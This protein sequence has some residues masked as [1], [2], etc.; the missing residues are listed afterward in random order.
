MTI[1]QI[2]ERI[3]KLIE[4]LESLFDGD[5]MRAGIA[6]A[7]V[8]NDPNKP[9]YE[10][11]VAQGV[12]ELLAGL[13][14][15]IRMVEEALA[16]LRKPLTQKDALWGLFELLAP[17]SAGLAELLATPEA[18]LTRLLRLQEGAMGPVAA[19]LRLVHEFGDRARALLAGLPGVADVQQLS[20]RFATLRGTLTGYQDQLEA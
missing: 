2:L 7:R 18:D 13:A 20:G 16:S 1:K 6:L 19:P 11:T 5:T 9:L 10:P 15:A 12:R 8:F 4:A 17:L 3:G 14:A